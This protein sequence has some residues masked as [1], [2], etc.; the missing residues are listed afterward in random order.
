MLWDMHCNSRKWGKGSSEVLNDDNVTRLAYTQARNPAK[1]PDSTFMSAGQ[2]QTMLTEA[3][4]RF[5]A[6]TGKM[7]QSENGKLA[8]QI[9][10]ENCT[11]SEMSN[12]RIW[13]E[14]S[15]LTEQVE[16]ANFDYLPS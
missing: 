16:I 3:T 8:G 11:L 5:Q 14:T 2:L 4:E 15:K 9:Q 6:E 10:A 12:A 1:S 13:A 7:F